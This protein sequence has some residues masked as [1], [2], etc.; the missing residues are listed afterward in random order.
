MENK[1]WKYVK[2]NVSVF[3]LIDLKLA[4]KR[5]TGYD[6]DWN[7][8]E[9]IRWLEQHAIEQKKLIQQFIPWEPINKQ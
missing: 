5:D 4:Y 6:A 8:R 3:S 9:Y 2:R 7:R 1:K